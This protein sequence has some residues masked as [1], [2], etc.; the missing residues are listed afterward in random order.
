[1]SD[2]YSLFNQSIA[3]EKPRISILWSRLSGYTNICFQELSKVSQDLIVVKCSVDSGEAP[4][5]E[6]Q[7]A[8]INQ[9]FIYE[10]QFS[11]AVQAIQNQ[12]PDILLVSGWY[13]KDYTRLAKI[14]KRQ[15]T[16]VIGTCDNPWRNTFK[17]YIAG[18][19]SSFHVQQYFDKIWVPG[20]NAQKFVEHLGFQPSRIMTGLYTCDTDKFER[21]YE[22]RNAKYPKVFLFV[23]RFVEQKGLNTLLKAYQVYRDNTKNM[24]WELWLTGSGPLSSCIPQIEGMTNLGFKQPSDLPRIFSQS[25]VFVLPSYNESWGVVIHEAA[26][27]GMPIICTSTCGS[28]PELVHHGI[29]GCIVS[30]R[31]VNELASAME[32]MAAINIHELQSMSNESLRLSKLYSPRKWVET[33]IDNFE[34]N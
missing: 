11:Q 17:Q 23:G 18:V 15:G 14:L 9:Q 29:N 16:L 6:D 12:R 4:F 34:A 27:A 21:V 32:F 25:S 1:M 13:N 26:T 3:G 28:S 19:T 10:T 31:N 33:L 5:S 2:S 30:P 7:F 8:W 24:P 22:H 20:S